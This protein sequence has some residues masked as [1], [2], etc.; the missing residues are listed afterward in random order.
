[1]LTTGLQIT[2]VKNPQGGGEGVLRVAHGLVCV[3]QMRKYITLSLAVR[4]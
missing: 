2:T 4:E 3:S 1:M